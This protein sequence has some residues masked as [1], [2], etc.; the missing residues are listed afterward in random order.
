MKT[1]KILLAS[2]ALTIAAGV[3]HADGHMA[4]DMTLV[5]WGGAYQKSQQRAYV[6]PYLEMNPGVSAVWELSGASLGGSGKSLRG[7]QKVQIPSVLSH[8]VGPLKKLLARV[9]EE[10]W[11]GLRC[12]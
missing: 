4:D 9:W 3:A 7:R 10:V 5:S 1:T 2:T 11:E 6:E 12:L 8:R